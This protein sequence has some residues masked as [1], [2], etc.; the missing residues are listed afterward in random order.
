[1]LLAMMIQTVNADWSGTSLSI[2]EIESDWLFESNQRVSDTTRLNLHFEEKTRS[3]IGVGANIG[4]QTTRISN[5]SGPKNTE[6][7]NASYVGVFLRYPFSFGDYFALHNQIGYRYHSGSVIDDTTTD[8]IDWREI[9]YQIGLSAMFSQIRL[10]PFAVISNISGDIQR[11][12]STETFENSEDVS[13]GLSIDL[14][15]DPTSFVR[16]KFAAS[17]DKLFSLRFAREF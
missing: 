8:R 5:S 14:F 11:D 12:S 10:M 3:G 1:M 6:K 17:G 9:S 7:F 4:R 15:V 2:D 13:T 16:F